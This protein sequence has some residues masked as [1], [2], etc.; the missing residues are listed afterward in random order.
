RAEQERPRTATAVDLDLYDRYA[1]IYQRGPNSIFTITRE[2]DRLFAQL[3]GQ[4]KLEVFPESDR[5]FFYKAVAAQITFVA[6]GDRPPTV[7]VLLQSGTDLRAARL[8]AV[9]PGGRRDDKA[10]A[11]A[12]DGYV[13]WYELAAAGRVLAV[14]HSGD[15]L[16]LQETGRPKIE[17]LAHG[18]REF[19]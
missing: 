16:I 8:A 2:G 14:T 5:E 12:L 9:P 11:K 7:L 19:V 10:D 17:M 13:G 1:G 15:R 6:D 18:D 4:P 3:T